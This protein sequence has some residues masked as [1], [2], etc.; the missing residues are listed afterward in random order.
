MNP[1]PPLSEGSFPK[2]ATLEPAL[3]SKKGERGIL[4]KGNQSY[5]FQ[6]GESSKEGV[7]EGDI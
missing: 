2:E 7:P 5:K 4:G 3:R 1:Q 6:L